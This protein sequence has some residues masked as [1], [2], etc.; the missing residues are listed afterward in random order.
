MLC[1]FVMKNPHILFKANTPAYF[2]KFISFAIYLQTTILL[3][4]FLAIINLPI[5]VSVFFASSISYFF[6][7]HLTNRS[8]A[9]YIDLNL[10]Q[11][12]R[13]YMASIF[14][15]FKKTNHFPMHKPSLPT[16]LHPLFYCFC[17]VNSI[18]SGLFCFLDFLYFSLRY[19]LIFLSAVLD[20]VFILSF[21]V[22]HSAFEASIPAHGAILGTSSKI[23]ASLSCL[24]AG[25]VEVIGEHDPLFNITTECG[26]SRSVI[27]MSTNTI[28]Q[29]SVFSGIGLYIMSFIAHTIFASV[30][31]FECIPV[32]LPYFLP[33][34]FPQSYIYTLST[35]LIYML[36]L[37]YASVFSTMLHDAWLEKRSWTKKGIAFFLLT[38]FA[39][40]II[41]YFEFFAHMIILVNTWSAIFLAFSMGFGRACLLL[42]ATIGY[43]NHPEDDHV[44]FTSWTK[45]FASIAV[46]II[47]GHEFYEFLLAMQLAPNPS[48][49]VMLVSLAIISGFVVEGAFFGSSHDV[50]ESSSYIFLAKI[51]TW[52][53]P[54]PKYEPCHG[55]GGT[56][57]LSYTIAFAFCPLQ[58][59]LVLIVP[60]RLVFQR[61]M[62]IWDVPTRITIDILEYDKS[63]KTNS[64]S[65][66]ET[67]KSHCD[68]KTQ[69]SNITVDSSRISNRPSQSLS[70]FVLA[71]S[72]FNYVN[73]SESSCHFKPE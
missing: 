11:S 66:C 56:L 21:L 68:D 52:L 40:S 69:F 9:A 18:F 48:V 8:Y 41:F 70:D 58:Y 43:H 71:M 20:Q 72:I 65:K 60:I 53:F 64:V 30:V 54:A 12:S 1:T 13:L 63:I 16:I 26:S 6:Y 7:Y 31:L 15:R 44:I 34:L 4:H 32:M 23:F 24:F 73:T 51:F 27:S 62:S 50:S 17:V 42:L 33:S 3:L 55:W 39:V 2:L 35:A 45:F 61:I 59:F 67:L 38:A 46:G 49:M 5:A 37:S 47:A 28:S 36:S 19:A 14:Q 22:V 10:A 29:L 25:A 57:L